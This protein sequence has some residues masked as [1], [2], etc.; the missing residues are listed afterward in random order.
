[1]A[2]KYKPRIGQSY[3]MRVLPIELD[4]TWIEGEMMN[5]DYGQF[6]R[7]GYVMH[8]ITKKLIRIRCDIADTAFSIP[9]TTNNEYGYVNCKDNYFEFI[10]YK[11]QTLT[12]EKYRQSI[13]KAYK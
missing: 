10:P 9:A 2:N 5:D 11:E 8:S 3:G 6:H 12:P 7:R 4:N 1:M 13:K